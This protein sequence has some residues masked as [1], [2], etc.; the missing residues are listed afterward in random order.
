LALIEKNFPAGSAQHFYYGYPHRDAT[1]DLITI[2]L[3]TWQPWDQCVLDGFL[4]TVADTSSYILMI[5]KLKTL[6]IVLIPAGMGEAKA[7]ML[8]T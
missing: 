7:L 6:M 8:S 1:E 2:L 4:P 5:I 3:S